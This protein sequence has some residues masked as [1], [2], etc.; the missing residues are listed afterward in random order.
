MDY[1]AVLQSD[2]DKGFSKRDLE[3]LIGL[4][5]NNLSGFMSSKRKFS[6]KSL[7][8]IE[9]WENSE[10]PDPLSII[11]VPKI[12]TSVADTPP[13]WAEKYSKQVSTENKPNIASLSESK[14]D[15]P[16]K[17]EVPK[18]PIESYAQHPLYKDSDPRENS[19][20][21]MRKYDCMS[22]NELEKLKK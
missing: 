10:K 22:Y 12:T 18:K 21:F 8:K 13:K 5:K 17:E 1:K 6:K 3:V 15:I 7:L 4:P 19:I 9:K 20:A 2:L 16:K 11:L 14:V